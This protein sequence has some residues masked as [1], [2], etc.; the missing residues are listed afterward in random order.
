CNNLRVALTPGTFLNAGKIDPKGG[1]PARVTCNGEESPTLLRDAV[2]G[3]Q[4][5]AG[6]LPDLFCGKERLEE[7]G[8]RLF[9]DPDPR[10]G[11]GQ[12]NVP[13]WCAAG[14]TTHEIEPHIHR[15]GCDPK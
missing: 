11:D 5:Q 4:A 2:H 10:V 3:G 8:K 6:S 7:M 14:M 15:T 12:H 13:A 1:A 9:G